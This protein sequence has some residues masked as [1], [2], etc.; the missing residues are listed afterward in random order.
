[1]E[2]LKRIENGESFLFGL[3]F[4]GARLRSHGELARLELQPGQFDRLHDHELRNK[5]VGGLR[6]AGYRHVCV[7]LEGYRMGSYDIGG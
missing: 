2:E 4:E 7:D 1:V 3:G 6:E 5:I